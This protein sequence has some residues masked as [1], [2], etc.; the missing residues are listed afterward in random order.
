MKPGQRMMLL[1][2]RHYLFRNWPKKPC[3]DILFPGCSFPSQFPRT[4]DAL[5][6]LCAE[7]GVGVAYDC[8]GKPLSEAGLEGDARRIAGEL[9]GFLTKLGVAR[10]IV[11]C[12]NCLTY[13][14]ESLSH[15]VVSIYDQLP[16]WGVSPP[17]QRWEGRYFIP[18]PDKKTQALLSQIRALCPL[19]QMTP[20]ECAPC[21]GLRGD[22]AA[23]GPQAG[24]QLCS[25]VKGEVG[26]EPLYT[27]CASCSGQFQRNGCGD[28]RHVLSALLNVHEHPDAGRAFWNRIRTKWRRHR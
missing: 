7:H 10:V 17:S 19:E 5:E 21:C 13:L 14:Q 18:C 6:H 8:C 15:P 2:K 27:Y 22:I 25:L 9:D 20:V 12:P 1:E 4:M 16:Q 26:A 24:Q 11:L 28:V 23:H 3:R